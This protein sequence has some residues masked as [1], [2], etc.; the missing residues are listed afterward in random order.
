MNECHKQLAMSILTYLPCFNGYLTRAIASL[1]ERR[2]RTGSYS[3]V[4]IL[5]AEHS[6]EAAIVASFPGQ[7]TDYLIFYNLK[8]Y[9]ITLKLNK[10]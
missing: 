4:P 5:I 7:P 10:T 8:G 1:K 3:P 2:F 6:T 9:S